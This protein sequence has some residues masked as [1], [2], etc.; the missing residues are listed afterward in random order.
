LG[1]AM[2]SSPII[3]KV[4]GEVA[5]HL[6]AQGFKKLPRNRR[7]ARRMS[8][9]VTGVIG[10]THVRRGADI[11]FD[12]GV[13]CVCDKV[14]RMIAGWR[15]VS[16]GVFTTFGN[17]GYVC[18]DRQWLDTRLVEG[19]SVDACIDDLIAKCD[20]I[21]IPFVLSHTDLRSVADVLEQDIFPSLPSKQHERL[22]VIYALLG[23]F[24]RA[25]EVVQGL[26]AWSFD[27]TD[28]MMRIG[29]GD[30]LFREGFL[31]AFGHELKPFADELGL[32]IGL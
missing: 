8:D 4:Y 2:A 13:G 18:P 12:I 3:R 10:L 31:R 19:Q 9:Q 23:E 1:L 16:E 26:P 15:N 27:E 28:W 24:R 14:E 11:L 32:D 22:A 21:A 17:I 5:A 25:V 7:F 30:V 29:V 6:R 20:S